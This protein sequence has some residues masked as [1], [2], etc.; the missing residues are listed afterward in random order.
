MRNVLFAMC[1]LM[2]A[3]SVSGQVNYQGRLYY[4]RVC[5]SPNCA[6]CNRIEAGLNSQRISQTFV[7]STAYRTPVSPL[8]AKV[9]PKP[10]YR[11]LSDTTL[12]PTPQAA[13]KAMLELIDIQAGELLVDLGCGDGRILI[14]A[15][16]DY[17]AEAVGIELN[18]DSVRLARE[19]A[20]KSGV[21][22][23]VMVIERDILALEQIDADV[24]TMFLFPELIDAAWQKIRDGTKVV[25]FSHPLPNAPEVVVRAGF[26]YFVKVKGS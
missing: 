25:S 16:K 2:P 7:P 3:Y 21:S 20:R 11:P 12:E 10:V 23:S 26:T 9:I 24:V 14:A 4:G 22:G 19:N 13:V 18:P 1:L 15:A 6:M 5:S 8:R 17:G